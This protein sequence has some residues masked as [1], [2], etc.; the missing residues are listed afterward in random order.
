MS[1]PY[2]RPVDGGANVLLDADQWLSRENLEQLRDEITRYLG[3]LPRPQCV[4]FTGSNIPIA[5][6]DCP[7]H[8]PLLR[9]IM[10]DGA[11]QLTRD[12][13]PP[14]YYCQRDGKVCTHD[15]RMTYREHVERASKH[16]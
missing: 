14:C 1:D 8:G 9:E 7:T 15:G 3:D 13:D 4:C 16:R 11:V 12:V 6:V 5:H 10:G 2:L